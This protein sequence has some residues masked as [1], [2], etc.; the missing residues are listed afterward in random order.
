MMKNYS[1]FL[2]KTK[3][4]AKTGKRIALKEL[5]SQANS[6]AVA[7]INRGIAR[8]KAKFVALTFKLI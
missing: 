5:I 2:F 7:L 8:L 1:K 4:E 6:V 3:I